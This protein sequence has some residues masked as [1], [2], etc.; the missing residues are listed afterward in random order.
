MPARAESTTMIRR[1]I[2][3]SSDAS[4]PVIG[5]GT[6]DTFNVGDSA[7]ARAPLVEVL[8]AFYAAGASLIDTSPMYGR[9]EAVT[10]DLVAQLDAAERTFFA[11]KVWTNGREAGVA[12]I[13]ESMR[14]LKTPRLDL[15]Q[16]HNL[17]DWQ[18]H[19]QTLER[20][21]DQGRLRYTGIT[22]YVV[23]AHDDLE[24]VLR[25]VP[26]DF[27]QLNYSLATRDAEARLLPYCADRGIAVLVN[28][29][30]EDGALFRQVRDRALPDW[31]A[32]I[33]CDSWA[34]VFLKYVISH[35]AVTCVIP[36]TSKVRHM[37]DNLGAGF[38]R[39][40]DAALRARMA[41][42]FD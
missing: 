2:P 18:T 19:A 28:R 39:L 11:T 16:I 30:F 37:R 22:H 10:G 31:A 29:P 7:H 6:S 32:E 5:M 21:R 20:L 12:Q 25:A 3:G 8:E 13:E 33:D 27:V 24:S 34:Q 15:L 36:A 9:A 40:P 38:G 26:F 17:V 4:L 23:S 35:P 42:L 41:T 1:K 14:L